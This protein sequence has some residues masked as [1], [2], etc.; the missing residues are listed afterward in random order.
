V[1]LTATAAA[2]N[3]PTVINKNIKANNVTK[4]ARGSVLY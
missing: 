4:S 2:V 1:K 3:Q